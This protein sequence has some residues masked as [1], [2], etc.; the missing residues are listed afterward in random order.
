MSAAYHLAEINVARAIA[1]L[2]SPEL[3]EFM[4]AL[5]TINGLAERSPGFVWRFKTDNGNATSVRLYDDPR[6]IVNLS[7]WT[8][9]EALRDY[10]YRTDHADF[11]RRRRAWFEEWPGPSFALWWVPA[12]TRPDLAEGRR[13]LE[14]LAQHGPTPEA[15]GFRDRFA[16]PS[17]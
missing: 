11:W 17:A 2:D 13:R 8:S 7:V 6:I 14:H 10:A 1:P 15:F 12:G 5:D 16:P 4:D 3:K 9:P